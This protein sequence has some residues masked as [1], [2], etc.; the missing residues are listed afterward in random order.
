MSARSL[1][2]VA[3]ALVAVAARQAAA[4]TVDPSGHWEGAIV[5]PFGEIPIAL[6]IARKDGQLVATYS[7]GDGSVSGFPLSD[8]ALAGSELK[9]DLK[10]N[11]G[12]IFRGTVA[13]TKMTGSFAAFAGTVPFEVTR[14]G[15]ARFAA[16]PPGTAIT[17]ELQGTWTARLAAGNDSL[18]FRATLATDAQGATTAT[19]ADDHGVNVPLKVT[20]DGARVTFEIPSAH[21][22]FTGTLAGDAI[23]GTYGEGP[24]TVPMTFTRSR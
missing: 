4:Q 14:T 13:T 20:Q 8:V 22:T 3:L 19:I 7:R 5:A 15:E 21:G 23:E 11:G 12:G 16:P 24:L 17:R 9:M 10:A 1:V 2:I 6:D 18:T